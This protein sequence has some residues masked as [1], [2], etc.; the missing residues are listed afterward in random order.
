MRDEPARERVAVGRLPILLAVAIRNTVPEAR[1]EEM[2]AL[3]SEVSA[4]VLPRELSA[5]A[6]A[7]LVRRTFGES[8]AEVFCD[9]CHR[10]VGRKR[11]VA[12]TRRRRRGDGAGAQMGHDERDG[13]RD[14]SRRPIEDRRGACRAAAGGGRDPR[15]EPGAARVLRAKI[16]LGAALAARKD[17]AARPILREV[18]DL[19]TRNG[20]TVLAERARKNLLA[21]GGRPRRAYVTGFDALTP[22]EQR[23][24]R[25]AASGLSNPAIAQSLFLTRKTIETHLSNVYRKL[26]IRSREQLPRAAGVASAAPPQ[27][28]A[29]PH[30]T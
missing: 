30:G 3:L 16:D 28:P 1:L 27:Y 17:P 20:A 29:P 5:K 12:G 19:C 11:P 10:F 26:G 14:E 7:Q 13:Y 9:P 22:S 25:L 6:V 2:R 18:L 4:L 23:V 21:A 15:C 24:A 8:A